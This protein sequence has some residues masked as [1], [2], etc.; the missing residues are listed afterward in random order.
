MKNEPSFK[1]REFFVGITGI[2]ACQITHPILPRPG[3]LASLETSECRVLVRITSQDGNSYQGVIADC[4]SYAGGMQIAMRDG[5][6]K[7]TTV[8]FSIKQIFCVER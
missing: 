2:S 1:F 7:G 8:Q 5:L 3:D 4:E 6:L